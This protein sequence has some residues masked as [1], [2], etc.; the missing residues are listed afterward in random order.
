MELQIIECG[1]SGNIVAALGLAW[2]PDVPDMEQLLRS[3]N[4]AAKHEIIQHVDKI[5]STLSPA[6]LPN[7]TNAD[8]TQR[9]V[10]ILQPAIL[11]DH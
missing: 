1:L 11:R 7:G 6:V 5:V 3:S 10:R 4:D 8:S 9:Q 2:L